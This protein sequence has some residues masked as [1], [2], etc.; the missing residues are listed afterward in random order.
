MLDDTLFS[1][2]FS[3]LIINYERGEAMKIFKEKIQFAW[4]NFPDELKVLYTLNAEQAGQLTF[5]FGDKTISN[6][7]V[8]ASGRGGS[9]NRIHLTELGKMAIK[10]PAAA[11]EFIS[12]TIPSVPLSGR[13]DIESTAEGESGI[14]HKMFWD[15]W[16]RNREPL[17]TEF[18]AHFY[19]WTWDDEEIS[20]VRVLIPVEEME[21]SNTFK[22]YK[23]KHELDDRQITFYYLKWLSVEK[24]WNTMHQE[25]PT[26][27][28]EAFV[29]SGHHMF[30]SVVIDRLM[31]RAKNGRQDGDWIFYEPQM[32]GHKYA[33]GVDVAE[34]VGQDSSTIVIVDFSTPK[35][36]VVAEYA[37][38]KIAPDHLAYEIKAGAE[39]YGDAL[40]A[41]E[42][43]NHGHTTIATLKGIYQNMYTQVQDENVMDTVTTKYGWLTTGASKPKMIYELKSAINKGEL[44]I[45]S[46]LILEEMR[47]YDKEDLG[48]VKFRPDQTRHWDRLMAL[49]IAYQMAPFAFEDEAEITDHPNEIF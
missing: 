6:I 1:K 15:A 20:K 49:G 46:R 35:P 18:K 23:E 14:F 21:Q 8:A 29:G 42:R 28:E 47:T 30:D 16:E 26:T 32:E 37:S 3:G 19:N 9:N 25:F 5:D 39:R 45:P 22:E 31:K 40:V 17:P 33:C 27:P 36:I 4:M 48:V 38:D 11:Q 12:G 34:G 24:N 2:N 41:I 13:I 10:Y 7:A 44:E 43:N